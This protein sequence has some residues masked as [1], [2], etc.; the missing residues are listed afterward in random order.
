MSLGDSS[1]SY[2]VALSNTQDVRQSTSLVGR[3]S[4]RQYPIHVP[5]LL[6]HSSD[7]AVQVKREGKQPLTDR[8]L[9]GRPDVA[10]VS[11]YPTNQRLPC[12]NPGSCDPD[13][14][15]LMLRLGEGSEAP[16][17]ACGRCVGRKASPFE[18]R[19]RGFES[20]RKHFGKLGFKE[21]IKGEWDTWSYYGEI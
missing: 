20:W 12:C 1:M 4:D 10:C 14:R 5:C 11:T 13:S 21:S 17:G 3:S 6:P 2:A 19:A 7:N 15:R 8:C 16:H 18:S 9:L